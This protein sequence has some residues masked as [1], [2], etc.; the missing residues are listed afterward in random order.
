MPN[1]LNLNSTD[2]SR[3]VEELFARHFNDVAHL[4]ESHK[5]RDQQEPLIKQL[6]STI[7]DLNERH[8]KQG[9]EIADLKR[10]INDQQSFLAQI[11]QLAALSTPSPLA[12]LIG[13]GDADL[14]SAT[15]KEIQTAFANNLND[16]LNWPPYIRFLQIDNVPIQGKKIGVICSYPNSYA[17]PLLT[18]SPSE[19]TE[20]QLASVE[21]PAVRTRLLT[22]NQLTKELP[23]SVSLSSVALLLNE[24]DFLWIPE[25]LIASLVLR[26]TGLLSGLS[27]IIKHSLLLP[28]PVTASSIVNNNSPRRLTIS[29]GRHPIIHNDIQVRTQLHRSGFAEIERFG[30]TADRQKVTR[31]HEMSP[32]LYLVEQTITAAGDDNEHC[33]Y[34]CALKLPTIREAE[35]VRN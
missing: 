3:V 7:H 8:L 12:N 14:L 25:P 20:I 13:N 15:R 4:V 34:Y 28:V 31:S 27:A 17:E 11:A 23:V 21:G 6:I 10:I 18:K 1:N 22:S 24:V 16:L 2:L 30:A 19:I 32:Y 35:R 26:C 33:E 9:A 5:N 29:D